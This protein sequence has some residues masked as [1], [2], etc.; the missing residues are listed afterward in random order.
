MYTQNID[1]IFYIIQFHNETLYKTCY[2]FTCRMLAYEIVIAHPC[3]LLFLITIKVF[4]FVNN[5]FQ[6]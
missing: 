2:A 3:Y 5:F 1:I 4:T 6:Q